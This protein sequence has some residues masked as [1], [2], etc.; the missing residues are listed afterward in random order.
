[1]SAFFSRE[2]KGLFLMD[3]EDLLEWLTE[4]QFRR[5]MFYANSLR[6]RT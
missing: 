4:F 6:K 5:E 3:G 1:M 2:V